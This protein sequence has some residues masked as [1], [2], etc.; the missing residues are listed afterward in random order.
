M[1]KESFQVAVIKENA[2]AVDSTG[3]GAERRASLPQLGK[4]S[5][6]DRPTRSFD[7]TAD[8]FLFDTALRW[9]SGPGTSA[10][11][12]PIPPNPQREPKKIRH[13]Q[14]VR[15]QGEARPCGGS[16]W[17]STCRPNIIQPTMVDVEELLSR[18]A[19]VVQASR[20]RASKIRAWRKWD[21]ECLAATTVAIVKSQA[22]LNRTNK[23]ISS[24]PPFAHNIN[25]T[26]LSFTAA[27]GG[28]SRGNEQFRIPSP[29]G[30]TTYGTRI[31]PADF[32]TKGQGFLR[33]VILFFPGNP[34]TT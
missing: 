8:C 26:S 15:C 10:N 31:T 7:P 16:V 13:G 28:T 29:G 3:P 32:P 21:R 20:N 12:G 24:E 9:F 17:I 34:S 4:P 2:M 25:S 6:R 1:V 22:L 30:Q 5:S 23:T 18:S 11:T 19:Q 33:R 14:P 27:G